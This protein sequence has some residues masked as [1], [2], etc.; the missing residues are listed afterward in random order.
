MEF[1]YGYSVAAELRPGDALRPDGR[2]ARR[3]RRAGRAP[4]RAAAGARARVRGGAAGARERADRPGGRLPAQVEPRL[5]RRRLLGL[6][7][8]GAGRRLRLRL[9]PPRV[10]PSV[11]LLHGWPGCWWDQ[12]RVLERLE[13][14]FQVVVARPARLRRIP[15][16]K[17]STRARLQ[18]RRP[19]LQRA[20]APRR[21]GAER[22][23]VSG[24]D[25]GS[26]WRGA[27]A[28]RAR[29]R[30]VASSIAPPFPSFGHRPTSREAQGEFWYQHFHRLPLSEEL[31]DGDLDA[32]RAPTS[33]TSGT[34]GPAIATSSGPTSSTISPACTRARA[35]SRRASP[36]T[37]P[38]PARRAS[39]R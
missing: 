3:P 14:D 29:A 11:V 23:V 36:G 27:R 17:T 39:P 18:R 6:P 34:T 32:V 26:R 19:G 25:V 28:A 2:G 30:R 15:T 13:G 12:R 22:V 38:A 20:R 21:A 1:L 35:P 33:A 5:S 37:E 31:L 24:Y 16:A 9:R 7:Q 4:E 8:V 10:R